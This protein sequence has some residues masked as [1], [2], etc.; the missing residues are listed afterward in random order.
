MFYKNLMNM[1]TH[2]RKQFPHTMVFQYTN[3]PR[4]LIK[5][6][7]DDLKVTG[8]MRSATDVFPDDPGLLYPGSP[9]GVYTY[10][11]KNKGLMP[12]GAQVEESNYLNTRHDGKGHKPTIQEILNFARDNLHA[13]YLFW[14]R[15]PVIYKRVLEVLNAKAQKTSPTGGLA[16]SCPASYVSCTN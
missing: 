3:Y 12:L 11:P 14:T 8:G 1:D 4:P 9:P 16:A 2:M 15:T 6:V 5:S 10:F 13:N 7:V